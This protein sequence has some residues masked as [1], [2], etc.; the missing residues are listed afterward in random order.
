MSRTATWIAAYAIYII[1]GIIFSAVVGSRRRH[2]SYLEAAAFALGWPLALI[3]CIILG[4][5]WIAS[6]LSDLL[7]AYMG[8]RP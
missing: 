8:D 1:V 2:D 7:R 5:G 6:K 4:L 3:V